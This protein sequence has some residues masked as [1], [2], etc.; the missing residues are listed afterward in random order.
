MAITAKIILLRIVSV[1]QCLIAVF[2]VVLGIVE[3]VRVRWAYTGVGMPIWIGIWVGITSAFGLFI[4]F[5]RVQ[6]MS[7][8]S[9]IPEHLVMTFMGFSLT[10]CVMS[11]THLFAHSFELG[12]AVTKLFRSPR[13]GN[14]GS[15]DF[16]AID[17]TDR[18]SEEHGLVS[19]IFGLMVVELLIATWSVM[20]CLIS[21]HHKSREDEPCET[22]LMLTP[23]SQEPGGKSVASRFGYSAAN[24]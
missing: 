16:V 6:K 5:K 9:V 20:I 14:S 19:S 22:P 1:M 3:R 4:T 24:A 13:E 2:L 7:D 21:D 8:G 17:F 18:H 15:Y 12:L 11:A 23:T 10:C